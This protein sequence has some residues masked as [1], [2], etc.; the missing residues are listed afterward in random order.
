MLKVI[1]YF[2]LLIELCIV[3]V[4][5][6]LIPMQMLVLKLKFKCLAYDVYEVATVMILGLHIDSN[7]KLK[8]M[9]KK[10]T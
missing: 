1:Y 7:L 8:E 2:P 10:G 9:K 6:V 5:S 3:D 4:Y